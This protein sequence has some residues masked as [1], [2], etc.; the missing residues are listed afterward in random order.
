MVRRDGRPDF[1]ESLD[2]LARSGWNLGLSGV[3]IPGAGVRYTVVGVRGGDRF[4][5]AGASLSEAFRRAVERAATCDLL[6]GGSRLRSTTRLRR[7]RHLRVE[8]PHAA[9]RAIAAAGAPF[10]P[11][12]GGERPG[13]CLAARLEPSPGAIGNARID[14]HCPCG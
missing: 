10:R 2:R 8:L 12:V 5:A 11:G 13:C 7:N 14:G 9:T 3:A 1:E 6:A 4:V